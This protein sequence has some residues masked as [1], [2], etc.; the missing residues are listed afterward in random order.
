[1][2]L[3]CWHQ[4]FWK[5]QSI[6]VQCSTS[7]SSSKKKR[8]LL[9][10]LVKKVRS[11]HPIHVISNLWTFVIPNP[12]Y[13]WC[14]VC[15]A[16]ARMAPNNVSGSGR[17]IGYSSTQHC[18]WDDVK[19][20]KIKCVNIY[21]NTYEHECTDETNMLSNVCLRALGTYWFEMQK[22]W[23]KLPFKP[24]ISIPWCFWNNA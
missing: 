24:D 5:P 4:D 7:F 12:W 11:T 10:I 9:K 23:K 1:M 20:Y 13:F 3:G 16:G 22:L 18:C 6:F 14:H 21:Y 15:D 8:I 19:D 2:V 17:R